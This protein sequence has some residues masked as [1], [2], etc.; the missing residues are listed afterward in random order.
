MPHKD[1]LS[2]IGKRQPRLDGAEKCSG[3]SIFGDDVVLEVY[4]IPVFNTCSMA[5]LP[6][7]SALPMIT[8]A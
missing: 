3:R 6:R 4:F 1:E 2:V 5:R 8:G 7:L